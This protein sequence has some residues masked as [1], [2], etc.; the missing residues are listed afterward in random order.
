MA[1]PPVMKPIRRSARAIPMEIGA[2]LSL[3]FTT[4][5]KTMP[6][7]VL[8]MAIFALPFLFTGLYLPKL[9]EEQLRDSRSGIL[10]ILIVTF[11]PVAL[12]IIANQVYVGAIAFGAVESLRGRSCAPMHSLRVAFR[13]LL[14]LVGAAFL[15]GLAIFCG[16]MALVIPGFILM[17]VLAVAAPAVVCENR[18][19]VDSLKRSAELTKGH[20]W[21]VFGALFVMGIVTG[22]IGAIIGFVAAFAFGGSIRS[23]VFDI[24]VQVFGMFVGS[25]TSILYAVIYFALRRRKDGVEVDDI[26]KVFE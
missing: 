23:T 21:T 11:V 7:V 17:S 9:L 14:P 6:T 13:R 3:S 19:A 22:I 15:V 20:R 16:L 4:W 12:S 24:L 1:H 5:L 10:T 8:A 25:V 26:A 2:L 18:G